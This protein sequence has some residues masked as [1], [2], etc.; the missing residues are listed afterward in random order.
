MIKILI[1]G[2]NGYVGKSLYNALKSN[3]KYN[4]T[5]LTRKEC[6]LTDFEQVYEFFKDKYFD[7]IIH[8]AVVGGSRLKE[9]DEQIYV[10]NIKMWYALKAN[11]TSYGRFINFG[12]GA[13]LNPTSPYAESK[14]DIRSGILKLDNFYNLR[15]F[16]VFDEN[17]WETRFIKTC[18]NNY[19]AKK[20]IT[21]YQ[22]RFFSFFYMEDLII[23]VKYYIDS[24][25]S[26][27]DKKYNCVYP[28]TFTLGEIAEMV[29]RLDDYKVDVL[30]NNDEWGINYETSNYARDLTKDLDMYGLPRGIRATYNKLKLK[31]YE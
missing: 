28:L 22:D 12:S 11:N 5:L 26:L 9:E 27:L 6:D 15:I 16:G 14:K 3:N 1:T 2:A 29:N 19:I 24:N 7:V 8:T 31:S 25:S 17:E 23:L 18:I 30:V 4:I 10:Q 21:I 20:P 13:E